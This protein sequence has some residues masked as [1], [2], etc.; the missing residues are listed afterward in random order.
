MAAASAPGWR[1]ERVPSLGS[2][3]MCSLRRLGQEALGL[4]NT[5]AEQAMT[6]GLC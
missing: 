2:A 4:Q 5:A 6:A 1:Q 3:L